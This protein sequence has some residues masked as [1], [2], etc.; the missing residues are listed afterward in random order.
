MSSFGIGSREYEIGKQYLTNLMVSRSIVG[1]MTQEDF[2]NMFLLNGKFISTYDLI[3]A[4]AKNDLFSIK[5]FKRLKKSAKIIYQVHLEG[6]I[7]GN[8]THL[9]NMKE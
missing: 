5:E 7:W 4:A 2:A 1:E 8:F 3:L 6:Q 9:K